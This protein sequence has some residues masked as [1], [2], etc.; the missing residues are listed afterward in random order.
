MEVDLNKLSDAEISRIYWN[1]E[2]ENGRSMKGN[3]DGS[4]MN[5]T[6]QEQAIGRYIENSPNARKMLIK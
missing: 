3:A 4:F 6:D 2:D 1:L 5:R